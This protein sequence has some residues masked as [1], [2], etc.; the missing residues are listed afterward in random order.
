MTYKYD[1]A[2]KDL[3]DFNEKQKQDV[4]KFIEYA[5]KVIKIDYETA[6]LEM[7]KSKR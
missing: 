7:Q 1:K 3:F 4:Q 5:K 2:Q 6:M